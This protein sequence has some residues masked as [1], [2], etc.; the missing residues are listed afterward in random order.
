[1]F[2]DCINCNKC[3]LGCYSN[4]VYAWPCYQ[5]RIKER[6][7]KRKAEHAKQAMTAAG[8]T[9]AGMMIVFTFMVCIVGL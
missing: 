6:K 7:A 2:K 9:F 3:D 4:D 1:M 8:I 5:E